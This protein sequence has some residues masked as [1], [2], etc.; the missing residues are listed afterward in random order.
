[1]AD[2]VIPASFRNNN[3]KYILDSYKIYFHNEI[4]I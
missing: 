1:M 3:T 4:I 2:L